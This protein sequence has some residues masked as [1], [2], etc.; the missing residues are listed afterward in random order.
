MFISTYI[1]PNIGLR[2]FN[3]FLDELSEAISSRVDKIICEGDFNAKASLWGAS[4]TDGRGLLL[5]RWAAERDLRIANVGNDSTCVR[6]QG[7]SIVDLTW[8]SPDLLSL[9]QEWC[10]RGDLESLSDHLYISFVV[11]CERPEPPP[12]RRTCRRWNA[13][14]FDVDLFHAVLNW[15]GQGPPVEDHQSVQQMVDLLDRVMEEACNVASPRI[16]PRRPRRQ[17][18]WWQDSVAFL[19]QGC[20]LARRLWQRAKKRRRPLVVITELGATYKLKRK[21]LRMEI[22]R[23]KSAAWQELIRSIDGDPWGLP[24]KIVLKKLRLSSPGLTELLDAETLSRLLDSLFPKNRLPDP[25]RDWTNFVWSDDW[26]INSAEVARAIKKISTSATKALGPD[27]F[28]LTTWKQITDEILDWIGHI[29]NACL[30]RGEFPRLWKCANLVLIPKGTKQSLSDKELPKVR[31]I[32]LINEIGKAFERILV[33]RIYQWQSEHPN[34]DLSVNQFGFRKRRSTCDALL[35][36]RDITTCAVREGGLAIV[37]SLDIRNAF[38]SIPW[39]VVRKTL[40]H[41]GFP[42]YLQRILDSYLSDRVIQY[43]GMNGRQYTRSMEAGVPQGSV[44]GPVLWNI[45]FDSVVRMAEDEE[46]GYILCY[47]D[48]T[49]IIVTGRD[50][51]TTYLRASILTTR[52]VNHI[53]SLGLTV[54]KDKT[55]VIIFH[56]REVEG[57]PTSIEIGDAIISFR[58]SIKYL[59]VMLDAWWTFNE[60]FRYV[61]EK[62]SRVARALNRLMPN[63]RGPDERRRRLYANVLLSVMLYGAPVW[64]NELNS[65]KRRAALVSLER[66]VAQRVIS[67]YRTVSGN[68]AFVLARLPPLHLLAPMRKRIFDRIKE[69]RDR[70][71]LTTEIRNVIQETEHYRLCEEWR[72]QLERPNTSGEF[73]KL[74]IVP[75]LEAWLSRRSGSMSFHITQIMTGHGCFAK[76]L[77]SIGRRENSSCDFCGEEVDDV[78]HTIRDCPAWDPERIRLKRKLGL[79]RDFT[80]GDVIEGNLWI[81]RVLGGLFRICR[82]SDEGKGG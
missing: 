74:A 49:L 31:P 44:L 5:T 12:N 20:S 62:T 36:V 48:D 50:P 6:P 4:S 67:A 19:R 17:A 33:E 57:V 23:L 8:V 40:R 43:I 77:H 2:E 47:A 70:G 80:L 45:A 15:R 3:V 39:R 13:R 59:E 30:I 46:Y 81:G 27:G 10:V 21:D 16:G 58:P 25:V 72:D 69:Y 63:L 28:R 61:V 56:T 11:S 60:H 9:V 82:K 22:N 41:G 37:V 1:S 66:T 51:R 18:Y 29:F 53:N 38:N 34:S 71:N 24:Y 64:G 73:T 26:L 35:A 54:A 14:E 42:T 76:F 7:N 65:S 55:E 68:A 75:R 32:C 78:Y 79:A 52:V